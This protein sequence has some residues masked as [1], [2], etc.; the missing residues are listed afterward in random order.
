MREL[1]R[2]STTVKEVAELAGVSTAT[3]SRVIS[4]NGTV[5]KKLLK[6]V[7]NAIDTLDFHPN[8][9]ARRLRHRATKIVGVIISDLQNPFFTTLVEGIESILQENGY[10][11]LL[12]NSSENPDRERQHLDTFFSE[13]VS[14]LIFTATGDD[15]SE[16]EKFRVAGVPL[17]A[18]DRKPS[19]F[20]VDLIHLENEKASFEAVNHFI[21]EGHQRIGLIAGPGSI[22]TGSER[23]AG[24]RRALLSSGLPVDNELVQIGNFRQEGGYRSMEALLNLPDPPS[25]VLVSNNLMTLGALQMIHQR[26]LNIPDQI[27]LIGFDDMAWASSL[28][29][30]LTVIAQ[31][32]YEMGI[33]A[34][35]LLLARIQ[36]PESPIQHVAF[37][38]KL[39][40]RAS[41]RCIDGDCTGAR[42]SEVN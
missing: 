26:R 19:D 13:H 32:V 21:K 10:L 14:G 11:L 24:Y 31:P 38:T 4:G 3:V 20:E 28:R 15:I 23:S 37:E 12:G 17:V 41:C 5:S 9:A 30:A 39:I 6:R 40:I 33:A 34:A 25:A 18:V 22:S 7:N 27:S 8:Q 1:P 42:L 36:K 35:R 16:Y 2:K 29:P